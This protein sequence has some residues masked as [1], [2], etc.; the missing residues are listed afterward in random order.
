MPSMVS[1][2]IKKLLARSPQI[3]PIPG[4]RDQ[5]RHGYLASQRV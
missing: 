3:R 5:G 2:A 4:E 1:E